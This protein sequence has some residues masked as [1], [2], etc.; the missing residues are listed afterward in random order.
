[1]AQHRRLLY[2]QN[3][4][5]TRD[6]AHLKISISY[7]EGQPLLPSHN[8]MHDSRQERL[9]STGSVVQPNPSCGRGGFVIGMRRQLSSSSRYSPGPTKRRFFA[10]NL[11]K[12][13]LCAVQTGDLDQPLYKLYSHLGVGRRTIKP[14]RRRRHLNVSDPV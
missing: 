11:T 6:V 12:I 4:H 7:H 1:M 10:D 3:G 2:E 13:A 8:P 14:T 5:T 9:D